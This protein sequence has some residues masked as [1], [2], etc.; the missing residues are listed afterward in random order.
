MEGTDNAKETTVSAEYTTA[1][2]IKNLKTEF[3]DEFSV[4]VIEDLGNIPYMVSVSMPQY[5]MCVKLQLDGSYPQASPCV[6]CKP[7]GDETAHLSGGLTSHLDNVATKHNPERVLARLVTSAKEWLKQENIVLETKQD[8]PRGKKKQNKKKKNKPQAEDE[9]YEEK[10]PPMKT[11]TDVISRIQWD[12]AFSRD[13]ITVGYMDRMLGLQEKKF[14]DFSWLAIA[15]VDYNTL[16]I[17]K[18]RIQYFKYKEVKVWDKNERLDNVF[19]SLGGKTMTDVID[20][21]EKEHSGANVR[22]HQYEYVTDSDD[23]N[24]DDDLVIKT[25]CEPEAADAATEDEA[26]EKSYP[27]DKYWGQKKRPTHFFALRMTDPE[28]VKNV[29]E[30]LEL[31]EE[32]EPAYKMCMIPA[33]RLHITLACVG[34]D[35]EEDIQKASNVLYKIR[36]ELERFNPKDI[37]VKVKGV[38]DFF[39]CV[40]YGKIEENPHFLDFARQFRMSIKHEG[41][42]IRDVFDFSPHMTLM[43]MKQQHKV[44]LRSKFLDIDRLSEPVEDKYFGSQFVDNVYLCSMGEARQSDGFYISPAKLTFM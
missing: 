31:M 21:Y 9:V 40:L 44:E 39:R 16:A 2:E 41:V 43:K 12:A 19:G 13:D 36:S 30:S 1:D 34:L 4:K 15:T 26:G 37:E 11:A 10:K 27:R 14:N 25:G 3:A 33:D 18:H 35:T 22:E 6:I 38:G 32:I 23:D 28:L 24:D 7:L 8:S 5:A 20:E 29:A 42:E 17:P